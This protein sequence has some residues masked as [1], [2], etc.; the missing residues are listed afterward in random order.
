MGRKGKR[1]E[2]RKENELRT[3]R[4]E[5]KGRKRVARERKRIEEKRRK[6]EGKEGRTEHG[7]H[8]KGREEA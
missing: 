4:R 2:D 8:A 3:G 7:R 5:C 6:E 1:N